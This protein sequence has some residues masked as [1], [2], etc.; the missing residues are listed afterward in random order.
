MTIFFGGSGG[1]GLEPEG[2]DPSIQTPVWVN[3]VTQVVRFPGG[4]SQGKP[5]QANKVDINTYKDVN[6]IVIGYSAGG[7]TALIFADKYRNYQQTNSGGT[8]KITDI[9]VL[10]GTFTGQ[11]TD[12]RDLAKEWPTVLGSLL[13]WGTDIY[14]LDDRACGGGNANGYQAP[15][16]ANGTF[17]P[18]FRSI[19]GNDC[20]AQAKID[21]KSGQEHWD[22]GLSGSL[23]IG[24]NNSATFKTEVYNWFDAH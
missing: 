4:G 20:D 24:T 22:G 5:N 6:L 7:D 3:G 11:M 14:I 17:H 21:D 13:T 10:G 23:G 19:S 18:E 9:A 15:S 2:P 8:G 12:G 1:S 16:G